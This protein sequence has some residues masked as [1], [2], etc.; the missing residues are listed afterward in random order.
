MPFVKIGGPIFEHACNEGNYGIAQHV[1]WGSGRRKESR[2]SSREEGGRE[3]RNKEE[4][5]CDVN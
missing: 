5:Q 4:I 3:V 2:R 1:G